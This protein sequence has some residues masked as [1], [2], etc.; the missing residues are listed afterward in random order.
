MKFTFK[1]ELFKTHTLI[2]LVSVAH[3]GG[4]IN[5]KH[6]RLKTWNIY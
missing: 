3:L 2:K 4:W 5:E 6:G 1:R